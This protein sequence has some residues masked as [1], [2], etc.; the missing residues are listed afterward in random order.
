MEGT[1]IYVTYSDS[2]HKR[3]YISKYI[4]Y[5]NL[6]YSGL[7]NTGDKKT[8]EIWR[9]TNYSRGALKTYVGLKQFEDFFFKKKNF[10]AFL[11]MVLEVRPSAD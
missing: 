4:T 9:R 6:G 1:K 5:V 2:A 10:F 11:K 7:W 3:A 8:S